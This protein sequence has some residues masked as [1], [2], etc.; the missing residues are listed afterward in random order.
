MIADPKEF[1]LGAFLRIISVLLAFVSGAYAARVLGPTKLGLS[2][3]AQVLVAQ[4]AALTCL[5]LDIYLTRKYRALEGIIQ[6]QNKLIS[7]HLCLRLFGCLSYISYLVVRS[8]P[9]TRDSNL[10]AM[11]ATFL[12]LGQFLSPMWLLQAQGKAKLLLIFAAIQQIAVACL[13]ISTITKESIAGADLLILG[14]CS[15]AASLTGWMFALKENRIIWPKDRSE[16]QIIV[17]EIIEA[18]WIIL[19]GLAIFAYTQFGQIQVAHGLNPEAMGQYRTALQVANSVGLIGSSLP[20][21]YYPR[22][23]KIAN[24]NPERVWDEQKSLARVASYLTGGIVV[25][26]LPVI[27][28]LYPVIFGE[29]YI[30]AAPAACILFA[31]KMIVVIN[32]IFC[33]GLWA[34]GAD[35]EMFIVVGIA[36]ILSLSLNCA[37]I[38]V[39]GLTAASSVGLLSEIFVLAAGARLASVRAKIGKKATIDEE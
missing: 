23:I 19:T 38:P 16:L 17:G 4:A 15:S 34:A 29:S 14:I 37:L 30:A 35:K 36:A 31:S 6:S 27:Y 1:L 26:S 32:G 11:G 9:Y 7:R 25:L 18:R 13:V 39:Y 20:L 33:W 24:R 28:K 2:G 21:F 10:L 5:N 12:A 8:W 22:L 3:L